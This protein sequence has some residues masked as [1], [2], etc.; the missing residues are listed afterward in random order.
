L[1]KVA[2]KGAKRK[3][4]N[5]TR[6]RTVERMKA[7]SRARASAGGVALPDLI[8]DVLGSVTFRTNY[9]LFV[10]EGNSMRLADNVDLRGADRVR[11]ELSRLAQED[12]GSDYDYSREDPSHWEAESFD[13]RD[14]AYARELHWATNPSSYVANYFRDPCSGRTYKAPQDGL[15]SGEYITIRQLADRVGWTFEQARAWADDRFGDFGPR[16]AWVTQ[17]TAD[18]ICDSCLSAR[19]HSERSR[20]DELPHTNNRVR[21]R[22]TVEVG[23]R[24]GRGI[25]I[26]RI[27]RADDPRHSWWSLRCECG[28]HYSARGDHLVS[29]RTVSCGC[30]LAET[31][32]AYAD[33]PPE[34]IMRR[35]L[36]E[37]IANMYFPDDIDDDC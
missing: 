28:V 23:H 15:R 34:I 16:V 24:Y 7:E 35:P 33:G 3:E 29:G 9:R 2:S 18:E 6:R 26:G 27:D 8:G 37:V 20:I 14:R 19:N 17:E 31:R 4:K 12:E 11:E 25:V 10:R 32:A 13:W 30:R 5:A 1:K 36:D 21:G 22:R